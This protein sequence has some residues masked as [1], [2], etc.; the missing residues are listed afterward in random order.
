MSTSAA[1]ADGVAYDVTR[2]GVGIARR[3]WRSVVDIGGEDRKKFLQG[4]L[5]ND[6]ES[7]AAGAGCRALLL[8]V[9]GH[10]VADFDV[11]AAADSLVVSGEADCLE[12]VVPT[13]QRYVLAAAVTFEER[14]VEVVGV[15]G[16]AAEALLRDAGIEVPQPQAG[17]HLMGTVD[18]TDV[19]VTRAFSSSGGLELHVPTERLES[20][21]KILEDAAGEATVTL[22]AATSEVLRVEAG[23][24]RY[25]AE[26]TGEEF[27][28]EVGLDEAINYDKGCYLGQ[29]TVARI[30]YRGQVNRLLRGLKLDESAAFG[31]DLAHD[32]KRVGHITSVVESP[33]LG[34]IGLG[35]VR[36]EQ[37]DSGVVLDVVGDGD[38]VGS[39]TV[40]A[41]PFQL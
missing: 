29:E 15:V 32:D 24:P 30:H 35:Y 2:S 26:I 5:S 13:L 9:K 36:R 39:A 33:R 19:R 37:A 8:D 18:G 1:V 17:A 25:G 20:V 6:V 22:D 4:L 38:S 21:W 11:F 14:G 28:Q 23:E 16:P 34:V 7:L 40:V 3:T 31:A 27:P 12:A 10:V 41:L